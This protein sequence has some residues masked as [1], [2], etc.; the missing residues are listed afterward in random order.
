[1]FYFFHRIVYD[2]PNNRDHSRLAFVNPVPRKD[3]RVNGYVTYLIKEA[4]SIN[5]STPNGPREYNETTQM[6][7]KFALNSL[8][9]ASCFPDGNYRYAPASKIDLNMIQFGGDA[10]TRNQKYNN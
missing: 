4:K 10:G 7:S 8:I 2:E 9:L 6:K 1:M 3:V 5:N